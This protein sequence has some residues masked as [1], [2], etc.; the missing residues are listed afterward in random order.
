MSKSKP[1]SRSCRPRGI[2]QNQPVP[3]KKAP[4]TV[5]PP[6]IARIVARHVAGQSV[7]AIAR[8]E[9]RDRETVVKIIRSGADEVRDYVTGVEEQFEGLAGNALVSLGHAIENNGW[10]A[11]EFLQR[12]GVFRAAGEKAPT[13]MRQPT[14]AEVR[15][16]RVRAFFARIAAEAYERSRAFDTPLV[17]IEKDL[18]AQEGKLT[19]TTTG[20]GVERGEE[21]HGS[22]RVE[23]RSLFDQRDGD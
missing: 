7:R 9:G 2:G 20:S 13:A 14:A 5:P 17:E 6:Q 15:E 19:G 22:S 16:E 1:R 10:L 8:A 21:N 12:L 3:A 4:T 11:L 23:R 18:H